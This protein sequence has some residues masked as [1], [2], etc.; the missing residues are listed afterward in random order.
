MVLF[1]VFVFQFQKT[2]R[3][4][5]VSHGKKLT[6]SN[7]FLPHLGV[8]NQWFWHEVNTSALTP[9]LNTGYNK[10]SH[11]FVCA[12]S[13]RWHEETNNF[14]IP[15]GE[16]TITLDDLACL[17]GIPITGRLL[18]D[19][20]LTREEG[21]QMMQ[22]DLLFTAEVAAKEVGRQGVAHP[23]L[24]LPTRR[25]LLRSSGPDILPTHYRSSTMSEA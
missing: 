13:E 4:N 1:V 9:L 2:H 21:I 14:H 25:L 15:V 17:L 19:R 22:D 7:L 10:I 11:G 23:V 6:L 24:S 5:G 8:Q 12:L 3:V 16:M 18:H 20:E